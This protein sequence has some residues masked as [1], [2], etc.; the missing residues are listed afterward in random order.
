MN[1]INPKKLL[2]S[3]WTAVSPSKKEKHFMVNEVEFDEEGV[4]VSCCIEAVMSTRS[5][6]ID[7][8][9]LKDDSQW[10]HGWK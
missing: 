5:I 10:I 1:K 8:N 7:W 2:H 6:S 9:V 3:K 4:V